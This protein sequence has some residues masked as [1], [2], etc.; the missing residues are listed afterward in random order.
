MT[1]S[2]DRDEQRHCVQASEAM[3]AYQMG[4]GAKYST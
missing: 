3:K 2:M 1:E 4:E